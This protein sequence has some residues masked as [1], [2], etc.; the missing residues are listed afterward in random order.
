MVRFSAIGFSTLLPL[1]GAASTGSTPSGE[2]LLGMVAVAAAFHVF[3]YVTN[4]LVDLRIDRTEPL[5][6]LSP[7]VRGDVRPQRALAIALVQLP[8][9][10]GLTAA[11]GGD[12]RTWSA[13]A[14]AVIGMTA[15]N[16]WGKRSALPLLTDAIQAL[17]WCCLALY[18]VCLVGGPI[19]PLT[20][21]LLAG[22][23]VYVMMINGVHGAL[24]DLDN[25]RRCDARTTAILLGARPGDDGGVIVPAALRNYAASLQAILVVIA[26]AALILLEPV[27]SP[28]RWI[29]ALMLSLLAA[30]L[31][32][33]L[34]RAAWR[35]REDKWRLA[36]AGLFHLVASLGL[37]VSPWVAMMSPGVVASAAAAYFLPVGTLLLRS[38][39]RWG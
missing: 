26:A 9:C 31:C 4:D 3:A 21:T 20:W 17:A 38:G 1:L 7:L 5:R 34:S 36:I 30:V 10:L 11:M 2:L 24:R 22:V 28:R 16:L 23:F 33:Q 12:R 35:A 32:A 27:A 14:A 25:D 8:I 29:A 15:Y 39:S 19:S 18:G 13:L 37:V 6:R